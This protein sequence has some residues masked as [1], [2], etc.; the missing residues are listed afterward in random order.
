MTSPNTHTHTQAQS[1]VYKEVSKQPSPTLFNLLSFPY[2]H[3]HTH[4][5]CRTL[6]LSEL[7]TSIFT[8]LLIVLKQHHSCW[9]VAGNWLHI[10]TVTARVRFILDP[11]GTGN[12][13]QE[14]SIFTLWCWLVFV[15]MFSTN[16]ALLISPELLL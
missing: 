1:N 4:T 12:V 14:E 6:H 7:V 9:L 2:I 10:E 13:A 3:T 16:S 11:E 8:L 15:K 5:E